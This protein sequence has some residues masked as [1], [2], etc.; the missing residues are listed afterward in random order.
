MFFPECSFLPAKLLL[1]KTEIFTSVSLKQN[2]YFQC[3][4]K[5]SFF[6]HQPKIWFL[7]V[8]W[9]SMKVVVMYL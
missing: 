8:L 3:T 2:V 7:K 5:A 1:L 6:S 9:S 4:T